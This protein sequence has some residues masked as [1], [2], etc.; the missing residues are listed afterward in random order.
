MKKRSKAYTEKA[1]LIQ[2]K[3][4]YPVDRAIELLLQSSPAKFDATVEVAFNLNV[5]PRHADQQIRGALVL[6]SSTGKSAKVLVLTNTKQQEAH[7]A[8]ADYVGGQDYINKIKNENWFEFDTIVATP[9]IMGKLGAIGRILG[10]KGYMPN[11]KLGTVTMDVAKAV[12]DIKKGKI[13]YR[14]DKFGNIH[15]ILGKTSFSAA[16]IKANFEALFDTIKRA[17]PAAVKGKYIK[18]ISLSTT[19]GPGIRLLP[20]V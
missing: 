18:N 12:S 4:L 1:K 10:P 5:D 13:T 8:G 19:M 17:K 20:E 16:A 15:T 2:T 14:V 6:P 3:K 7:E 11:P 9:D